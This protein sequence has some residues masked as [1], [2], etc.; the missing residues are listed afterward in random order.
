M[1]AFPKSS[2]PKVPLHK[3]R[4]H[5]QR[6]KTNKSTAPGDIPAKVIK[7]FAIFLCIPVA[8][9]INTG[10]S[11]SHW[12]KYYKKET[13]TPTPKQFPIENCE[14][15]PIANLLNLN[16]IMEQIVAEMVISDMK[17]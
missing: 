11:A 9:I 7:E 16:K 3:I 8:N 17:A 10:L 4:Y 15:R 6:I 1:S 5:L 13:I 14:M 12:P 2:I